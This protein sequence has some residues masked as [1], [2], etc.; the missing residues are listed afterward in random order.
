MAPRSD[1]QQGSTP[2]W[3]IAYPSEGASTPSGACIRPCPGESRPLSPRPGR[4]LR[5]PAWLWKEPSP[6]AGYV[7]SPRTTEPRR[8]GLV[9]REN[10]DPDEWPS[11]NRGRH[12][13]LR[14]GG[15]PDRDPTRRQALCALS[16]WILQPEAVL[17]RVAQ[18]ERLRREPGARGRIARKEESTAPRRIT[19]LLPE[20][21]PADGVSAA[22]HDVVAIGCP[23][24]EFF[25]IALRS[26][27]GVEPG[28]PHR[29]RGSAVV[30]GEPVQVPSGAFRDERDPAIGGSGG[31]GSARCNP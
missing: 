8:Q 29:R 13:S 21:V 20:C 19:A 9:Q 2:S 17:R 4:P 23:I 22:D 31:K 27:R 3:H 16:L 5:P 26:T 18:D 7:R 25:R 30:M 28:P 1:G 10:H 24:P 14:S 11:Q 6:T 15:Q 12:P